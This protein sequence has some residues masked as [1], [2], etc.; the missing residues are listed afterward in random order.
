VGERTGIGW[1]EHTFNGWW[2]C[3]RVSPACRFC[4]AATLAKRW[5]HDDIWRKNGPRRVLSD[6]TWRRPLAWNRA[7]ELAGVPARVFCGSM[8][9][10]FEDHPA[11]PPLRRRLWDLV[12]Q[13]P[14]LIWLLL[15]KRPENAAG[16]VPWGREW[17]AN[18]WPGT[19][20]E[21]QR[22]AEQRVPVLLQLP[23]RVHWLSCEPL[24]EPVDLTRVQVVAPAPPFGPGVHLDALRGHLLE[25]DDVLPGR[26]GWVIAGGESGSRH[27][28]MHP[29]W[30]RA[31]R[32]QC[33][34]AGVPF[35]FKQW[36]GRTWNAGGKTLDGRTWD[37]HPPLEPAVS[38]A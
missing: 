3:S 24:L 34:A 35:F 21:T 1:C 31:L 2:G 19:S 8:K 11:L 4:Y 18:V 5:G 9:D 29:D 20:V 6:E 14:W 26:V 30:A 10:V 16:M 37:Q 22:F 27:R 15:T 36:G 12:E 28:P 33:V 13:T 17:P 25:P 38:C 32:D 7:A 23:A